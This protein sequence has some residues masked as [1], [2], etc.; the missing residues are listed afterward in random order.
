[1][2]SLSTRTPARSRW[3]SAAG[4]GGARAASS[5]EEVSQLD[6]RALTDDDRVAVLETWQ[7]VMRD[8]R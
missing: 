4:A 3:L 2:W 5:E 8:C 7:Q 1:L 6:V